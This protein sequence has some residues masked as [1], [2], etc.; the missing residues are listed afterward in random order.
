MAKKVYR[1]RATFPQL[2]SAHAEQEARGQ[3]GNWRVATARALNEIATRPVLK[4]RRIKSV[5]VSVFLIELNNGPKT[6]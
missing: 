2:P 3:G 5:L 6:D 1:V 4:G